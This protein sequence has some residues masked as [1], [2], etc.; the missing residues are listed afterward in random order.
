MTRAAERHHYIHNIC[1]YDPEDKSHQVQTIQIT[2]RSEWQ[3]LQLPCKYD[4]VR[5]LLNDL[6]N[7]LSN[8][9][10]ELRVS[11]LRVIDRQTG[12]YPIIFFI[13][14]LPHHDSIDGHLVDFIYTKHDSQL[15]AIL[16]VFE[17]SPFTMLDEC[18]ETRILNLLAEEFQ[19]GYLVQ[20]YFSSFIPFES[21]RID[22]EFNLNQQDVH[23]NLLEEHFAIPPPPQMENGI[24]LEALYFAE[25][26]NQG[27]DDQ[28]NAEFDNIIPYWLE[29][30]ERIQQLMEIRNGF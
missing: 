22:V 26:A 25:I 3:Q 23:D 21:A 19:V 10:G 1:G 18:S 5:N 2:S 8:T 29:S 14:T 20:R 17:R 4:Y 27:N 30:E 16:E 24:T 11:L 28:G 13:H 7:G 12:S 9:N 6:D 15:L